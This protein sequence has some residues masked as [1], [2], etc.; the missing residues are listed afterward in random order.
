MEARQQQMQAQRSK[1][2]LDV[3][4]RKLRKMPMRFEIPHRSFGQS[5][6]RVTTAKTYDPSGVAKRS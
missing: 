3:P 4:E 5:S 1:R 2:L 6:E